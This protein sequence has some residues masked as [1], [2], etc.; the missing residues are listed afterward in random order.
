M[1]NDKNG[2]LFFDFGSALEPEEHHE[3]KDD[4]KDLFSDWET[5]AKFD[6]VV[7][8]AETLIEAEAIEA[9]AN[10]VK[11]RKS[12]GMASMRQAALGWLAEQMPSGLALKVPTALS[13]HN[14]DA[15]A[16]WLTPRLRS[17]AE[18]ER[19]MIV[20][21]CLERGSCFINEEK[22]ASLIHKLSELKEKKVFMEAHI[23]ID[24]PYLKNDSLF[25]ED[26]EWNYEASS[27]KGYQRLLKRIEKLDAELKHNT[28]FDRIATAKLADEYYLVTP[29]N[30]IS[31]NDLPTDWGL[32]FISPE[33]KSTLIRKANP[34]ECSTDNRIN[35]ALKTAASSMR[36]TLFAHGVSISDDGNAIF[37]TPPKKRRPLKK[38]I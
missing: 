36:E 32:I 30:L 12:F 23:R 24:E 19:V 38:I 35:L 28:V 20:Q 31:E 16:F 33:L 2:Q 15:V 7:E 1:P 27:N 10:N 14:A 25:E 11:K 26:R 3:K 6:A 29:E 8:L 37:H 5:D 4:E 21:I 13:H 18:I 34:C 17:H 9:P 22:R